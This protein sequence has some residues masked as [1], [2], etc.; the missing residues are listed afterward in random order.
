[1]FGVRGSLPEDSLGVW[2]S[3][4]P[5]RGQKVDQ[6]VNR[7]NKRKTFRCPK[8]LQHKTSSDRTDDGHGRKTMMKQEVVPGSVHQVWVNRRCLVDVWF[9][10][11]A[12]TERRSLSSGCVV[13]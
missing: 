4:A 12:G 3:V 7:H 11:S 6:G 1:M 9:G 10:V 2:S 5:P 8:E 13:F